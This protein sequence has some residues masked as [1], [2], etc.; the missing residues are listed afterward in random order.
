MEDK[1]RQYSGIDTVK[2]IASAVRIAK[3]AAAGGVH[4]AAIATAK[5]AAPLLVK[6]VVCITILLILLPMLIFAYLPNIFF[7]FQSSG[8]TAVSRMTGQAMTLGGFY[9]DLEDFENTQVDAIITS[10]ISRYEEEGVAIDDVE[11]TS[12]FHEE[13]L[14][15]FIAISS[16]AYRQDL[17][18]MTTEAVL[19]LAT[20]RLSYAPTL[21]A[22]ESDG[23]I[24]TT[25]VI[26][27]E[28]LEPDVFM[29]QLGFDEDAHNWAGTLYEVLTE[30]N[31]LEEYAAYYEPYRPRYSSETS[32]DGTYEHGDSYGDAIDTSGFLSPNTKNNIDLATYALRAWENNW[33]YVWGT[34]G[35]VLTETVLNYKL[36]QYPEG[37]G[38][39]EDFIRANWLGRRTADCIGFI[40][41][42]GWLDAASGSV[43]YGTNEMPDIG[44]DQMYANAQKAGMAGTMDTMPE[45]VG[46]ALWKQGHIGVYVGNG[47]AVEAMGTKYGVVR[48]EVS[49]RGWQGWCY[50]PYIDYLEEG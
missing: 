5:E 2:R 43:N 22:F 23:I 19:S 17:E 10:L 1:Q 21:N 24:K 37:V 31:A 45:L 9:M 30:S 39:Y 50:I 16:V 34:Y 35:N 27:I 6:L 14:R 13:D 3:A 12:D 32:Y 46:I 26:H 41:G 8:E 11:I 49:G 15:W 20:S 36:Q 18:V 47:Y 25:L 29:E 42:Y 28:H 38:Q 40:K 44:A 7:G 4:G 33:G 48:T